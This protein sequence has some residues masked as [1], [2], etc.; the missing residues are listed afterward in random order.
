MVRVACLRAGRGVFR[1][2]A[3][4]ASPSNLSIGR[5]KRGDGRQRGGLSGAIMKKKRVAVRHG[6]GD[7]LESRPWGGQE[8]GKERQ[9]IESEYSR[10]KEAGRWEKKRGIE[11]CYH[12]GKTCLNEAWRGWH[13]ES[14]PRGGQEEGKER[15]PIEP[16]YREERGEGR[17]V[18]GEHMFLKKCNFPVSSGESL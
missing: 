8:Q 13:A 10:V 9:P 4:S 16:E 5:R 3:R 15:Q 12:E 17:K 11:R 1:N 6:E 14:R 7:M 18:S 2:R